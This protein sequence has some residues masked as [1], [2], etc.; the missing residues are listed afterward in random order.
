MVLAAG[1]SWDTSEP[2]EAREMDEGGGG[3]G[4]DADAVP[5][6]VLRWEAVRC[7]GPPPVPTYG[8]TI[9]AAHHRELGDV[10]IV[11][12]GVRHGGY[13]VRSAPPPPP[14]RTKWTRRVPHLVLIGHATSLTPY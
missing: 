9:S 12:G 2:T 6:N 3:E 10:M 13:Q 7:L 1:S 8:P 11:F 14:S 5:K 4:A